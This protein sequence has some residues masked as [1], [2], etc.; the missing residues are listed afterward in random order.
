MKWVTYRSRVAC[1]RVNNGPVPDSVDVPRVEGDRFTETVQ[2]LLDFTHVPA[3]THQNHSTSTRNIHTPFPKSR[4]RA[5]NRT[6][7]LSFPNLD[8]TSASPCKCAAMIRNL[9]LASLSSRSSCTKA[10]VLQ[11]AS[12]AG[13][14]RMT[15]WQISMA[16]E[17]SRWTYAAAASPIMCWTW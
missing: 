14:M 7:R 6:H 10:S 3:Q 13:S 16:F 4:T 9:T 8:H 2:S 17:E 11:A 15:S 12:A 1:F 5:I